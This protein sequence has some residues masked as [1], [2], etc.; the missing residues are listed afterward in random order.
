[1]ICTPKNSLHMCSKELKSH[2]RTLKWL[3]SSYFQLTVPWLLYPTSREYGDLWGSLRQSCHS[4]CLASMCLSKRRWRQPHQMYRAKKVNKAIGM[5]FTSQTPTVDLFIHSCVGSQIWAHDPYCF[6]GGHLR[7]VMWH[8]MNIINSFTRDKHIFNK[9]VL[10]CGK[11][12]WFPRYLFNSHKRL[13]SAGAYSWWSYLQLS[14]LAAS[15]ITKC[16][17]KIDDA[18]L[19]NLITPSL[20]A[21]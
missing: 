3:T 14:A 17:L 5:V 4:N 8:E 19:R 6:Y 12:C 18:Y 7:P 11:I 13:C 15:T 1:M 20:F 2:S 10:Y 16:A 9:T 21:I